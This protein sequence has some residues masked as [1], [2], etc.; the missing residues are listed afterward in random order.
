MTLRVGVLSSHGGTNLQ[1][2]LDA[3]RSNAIDAVVSIVVS[4]NRGSRALA[5]A[6]HAG[7]EAI[8]VNAATHPEPD[9]LDAALAGALC[10]HGAQVVCLAGYMKLVGPRTLAA[11]PNRILNIH[12]APLPRFGGKG[13]Y[14][15]RVHE[16]VL[17]AG[18]RTTGVTVHVIDEHYDHGPIVAQR[19]AIPVFADDTPS[20][21]GTRVRAAEHDLYVTTLAQI[22]SGDIDLD[23]L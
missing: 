10:S 22:A 15:L 4:N 5:R 11:F 16:A 8:V 13:M 20:S 9:E 6:R 18:E 12:P 23:A 2:I 3:C 7:V 1:V 14:G 21:L 17:A 19:D